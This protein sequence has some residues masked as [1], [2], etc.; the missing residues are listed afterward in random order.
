MRVVLFRVFLDQRG[1]PQ[2][3]PFWY[4]CYFGGFTQ[5]KSLSVVYRQELSNSLLP[6]WSGDFYSDIFSILVRI[7]PHISSLQGVLQKLITLFTCFSNFW[8]FSFLKN[9]LNYLRYV[10]WHSTYI[11]LIYSIVSEFLSEKIKFSK[12][13]NKFSLEYSW[14]D[15]FFVPQK[16]RTPETLPIA[17]LTI[18]NI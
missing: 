18:N 11:T 14:L 4:I 10:F 16:D 6:S 7:I 17:M 2:S 15:L 13:Y 12:Y 9:Y 1:L 5:F 3:H 8:C